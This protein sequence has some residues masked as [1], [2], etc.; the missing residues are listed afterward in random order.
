[1]TPRQWNLGPGG[2]AAIAYSGSCKMVLFG[3]SPASREQFQLIYLA[4]TA[5]AIASQCLTEATG[6]L[7]GSAELGQTGGFLLAMG[8]VAN[9]G[10]ATS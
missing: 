9:V 3:R 10:I 2:K 7:G 1:M 4:H 8:N 6:F 5:A